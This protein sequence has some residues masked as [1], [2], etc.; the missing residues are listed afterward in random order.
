MFITNLEDFSQK[1][2]YKCN[3]ELSNYLQKNGFCLIGID[4]DNNY[5]FY[6]TKKLLD[7]L[8]KGGDE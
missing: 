5:C 1:L 2:L 7:F 4:K 3:Y 8:K 6:I